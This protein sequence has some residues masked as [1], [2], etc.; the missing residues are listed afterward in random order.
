MH[1]QCGEWQG[2]RAGQEDESDDLAGEEPPDAENRR[3]QHFADADLPV[4]LFGGIGGEAEEAEGRDK[5]RQG[6]EG[7]GEAVDPFF[8]GKFLSIVGVDEA[9]VEGAGRV[10]FPKNVFYGGEGRPHRY[11]G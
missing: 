3:T 6:C 10:V 7:A 11:C 9:V 1:E 2:Y 4:T 8:V 5:Y